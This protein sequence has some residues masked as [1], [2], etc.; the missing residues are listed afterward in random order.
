[1][2]GHPQSSHR[3]FFSKSKIAVGS[4]GIFAANYSE[5]TA[6]LTFD[7]TAVA[8]FAGDLSISGS[9][10]DMSQDSTGILD[11]PAGLALS[12][13]GKDLTQNSTGALLIPDSLSMLS[14]VGGTAILVAANSTGV[15]I[16]VGGAGAAQISTA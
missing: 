5:E 14:A 15:T 3:G 11:L 6:I 16:K 12:G 2:A 9:G 1:M 4:S 7:S 8:N 10:Q 13:E